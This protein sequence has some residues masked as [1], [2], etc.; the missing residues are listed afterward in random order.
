MQRDFDD[1]FGAVDLA[2]GVIDR[3][4]DPDQGLLIRI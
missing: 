2:Q 4:L 1:F 3:I